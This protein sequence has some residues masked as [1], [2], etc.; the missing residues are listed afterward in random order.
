M[1]SPTDGDAGSMRKH[2][3]QN[4]PLSV[5]VIAPGP[6]TEG[7]ITTVIDRVTAALSCSSRVELRWIATHRSGSAMEKL[8]QAISGFLEATYH[9]RKY[10][11]VHIH[12]S[13]KVSFVRKSAYFWLAKVFRMPVI[14]HFHAPDRGFVEFFAN[15]RPLASYGKF[16]LARCSYVVVLSKRWEELARKIIPSARFRIIYNPT[17]DVPDHNKAA[18]RGHSQRILYLG[19]LYPKKGYSYLIRAF[20]QVA[21]A[22]PDSE[23]ILAGSGEVAEAKELCAELGIS[24]R[25]KI[26]GWIKDPA[27][28][29]ELRKATIFVLPSFE[30]GLPMAVLEAM[31]YS[32]PVIV[33]PVGGIPDVIR[34][35]ENGILVE[36]GNTESIAAAM[37][38]LLSDR[39]LRNTLGK[40]ARDSVSELS[41]HTISAEWISVYEASLAADNKS[42]RVA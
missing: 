28:T 21:A 14:W 17:P 23:L 36:P 34:D 1:S 26:P 10:D 11:I 41:P 29:D 3:R 27:R 24:E 22:F 9:I 13:L 33:T 5:L 7:G 8:F 20:A 30:E 35:M 15:G 40:S 12:S 38:K 19:H 31:A 25:V 37:Q 4:K 6:N 42:W 39:V 2:D 32:L 16:V 18:S